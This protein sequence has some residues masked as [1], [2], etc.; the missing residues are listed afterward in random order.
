ML[1]ECSGRIDNVVIATSRSKPCNHALYAFAH[2]PA[3]PSRECT[4]KYAAI[5][6]H[7][8]I[9]RPISI[10]HPL[11]RSVHVKARARDRVVD[12][13]CR[14]LRTE[15]RLRLKTGPEADWPP[16]GNAGAPA[17]NGLVQRRIH[18][19]RALRNGKGQA[20]PSIS[21]SA[22]LLPS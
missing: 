17:V 15:A 5:S 11:R 13:D 7:P 21:S 22:R 3:S 1:C 2:P 9:I 4:P 8:V 16:S 10:R 12:N 6:L 20:L 19:L 14:L 18:L